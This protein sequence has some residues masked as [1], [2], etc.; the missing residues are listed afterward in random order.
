MSKTAVI[1][2]ASSGIGKAMAEALSLEGY[3]LGLTGRR[4][5]LLEKIKESLPGET[6]IS[7]MDVSDA[8]TTSLQFEELLEKM[9]AVDLVIISAGIGHP[10]PDLDSALEL[11]TIDTNVSGFVVIADAA[12]RHFQK[13]GKG[14]LVGISSIGALRGNGVGPAYSASKAFVSNYMEGLRIKALKEKLD[15]SITD[16]RPGFVDTPMAKGDGLFWVASPAKAASQIIKAF[17]AGKSCVYVTRRWN[18]VAWLLRLM[19]TKI[20]A[21]I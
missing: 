19:P 17:K 20:V 1:I 21:K 16:V 8:P 5:T 11:E 2:G 14:Q 13:Q 3:T 6:F 15:I 9:G 4:I 18:L 10:N 7:K 12:F